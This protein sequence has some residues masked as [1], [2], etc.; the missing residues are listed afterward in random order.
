MDI[1]PAVALGSVFAGLAI[2]GPIGA[3]IGIPIAAAIIAVIDTYGQRYG[4][5]SEIE[6]TEQTPPSE[7]PAAKAADQGRQDRQEATETEGE[8]SGPTKGDG[9]GTSGNAGS[10]ADSNARITEPY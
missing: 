5:I 9:V 8:G 10:G 6:E 4:I 2:W 3:L 7:L 1:H